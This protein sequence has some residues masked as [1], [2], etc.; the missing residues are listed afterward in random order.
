MNPILEHNRRAW[1]ERARQGKRFAQPATETDFDDPMKSMDGTGWLGDV[2]DK[3]V[4][5][6]GAGGGRH[7]PMLASAGARV[8][9]VDISPEMLRLEAELAEAR[10]L[11]VETVATSIDDLSMLPAAEY[12]AVM[13]PVSTC[14]V[15]DIRIAYRELARVM[16][17]GGVYISRHK[18]PTSLQTDLV[19][20]PNG[21]V[22]EE[23]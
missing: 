13:Q 17:P 22:I 6:L 3:R 14:Y 19:P 23:P 9:V 11:Q 10:G 15:P 12:D 4:L 21:F 2:R 16:K 1:D 5:C 20:G 18:Q 7:G 8:T